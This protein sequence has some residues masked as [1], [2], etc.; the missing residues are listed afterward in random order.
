MNIE[1]LKQ[2]IKEPASKEW[3]SKHGTPKSK[4]LSQ[5]RQKKIKK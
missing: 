4:A 3:F 5:N 1:H 2:M